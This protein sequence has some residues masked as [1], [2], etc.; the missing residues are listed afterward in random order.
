[1]KDRFRKA[2]DADLASP[3]LAKL[4]KYD[5]DNGTEYYRTLFTYLLCERNQ[6]LTAEK[7]FLHR[8]TLIYRVN[9]IEEIIG[10]DLKEERERLYLLLSYLAQNDI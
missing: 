4:R 5:I 7:L 6:T 9:R 3:A 2:V 8:N 10:T 1:M